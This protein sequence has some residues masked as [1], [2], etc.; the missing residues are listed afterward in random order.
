[1]EYDAEH[2][3]SNM[4]QT[5]AKFVALSLI[6]CAV[7]AVGGHSETQVNFC[8]LV[9]NPQLYNGKE[10]TVRATYKYGFEWQFLYCLSCLDG[11]KAWLEIADDL[12]DAS[13]KALKRAPKG[14]GTIN[15][16]V[17]GVFLSGRTYGHLNGYRYQLVAKRVSNIAVLIKGM[18]SPDEEKK[19]EQQWACGG[20]NPK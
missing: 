7:A 9:K 6:I 3:Y 1:M 2:R 17:Q 13:V 8:D 18:K 10:V 20:A 12:D 14:A 15:L 4:Q 16:T 19:A 11:G 5:F